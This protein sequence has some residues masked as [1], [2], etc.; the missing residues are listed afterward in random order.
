M[1]HLL[2]HNLTSYLARDIPGGPGSAFKMCS[3]GEDYKRPN[4]DV[5]TFE[6]LT[7]TI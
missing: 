2:L 5:A 6:N 3:S 4:N 7:E 1:K